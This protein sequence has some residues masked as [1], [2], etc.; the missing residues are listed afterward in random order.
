MRSVLVF[1]VSNRGYHGRAAT[2]RKAPCAWR[3]RRL[4]TK[5]GGRSHPGFCPPQRY[6][7]M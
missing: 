5:K 1:M 2:H 4:P 7:A 6:P 3:K